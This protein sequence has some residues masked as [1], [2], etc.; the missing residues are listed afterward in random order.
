MSESVE[1]RVNGEPVHMT[2][3][4]SVIALLDRLGVSRARVA[5]ERNRAILPRKDYGSTALEEGDVLEVVELV[6]GG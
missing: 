3:G 2:K 5:V 1:V 6:G 4:S